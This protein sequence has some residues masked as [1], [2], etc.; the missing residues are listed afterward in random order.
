MDFLNPMSAAPYYEKT[1]IRT[2]DGD[3]S[4][5]VAEVPLRALTLG[6]GSELTINGARWIVVGRSALSITS[7]HSKL[8]A[9]IVSIITVVPD[10]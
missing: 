8:S 5:T 3:Q 1:I 10:A 6:N 7:T 9:D 4:R 2:F